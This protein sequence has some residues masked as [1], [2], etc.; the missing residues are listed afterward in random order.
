VWSPAGRSARGRTERCVNIFDFNHIASSKRR[1]ARY[2]EECC[3]RQY[4]LSCPACGN[5]KLY[6]IEKG[7]RRRC[8]RCGHS[9]SRFGRRWLNRVKLS[10]AEWL[11]AAKLFEIEMPALKAA[12]EISISYPT[13]LKTF[14]VIRCAIA[15]NIRR[16]PVGSILAP[17]E[18]VACRASDAKAHVIYDRPVPADRVYLKVDLG[19]TLIVFTDR[20]LASSTLSWRGSVLEV[21]DLGKQY[22][23]CR[24]YC[25]ERG[26]W[27]YAKERLMRYRGVT[28]DKMPLYL[29]EIELRRTHRMG[30]LLE[31]ILDTLCGVA[32]GEQRNEMESTLESGRKVSGQTD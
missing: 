26:F 14:N 2:L 5:R 13:L 24:V 25:N 15:S 23:R 20:D 21:A 4:A 16:L 10:P 28:I 3:R 11:W 31:A 17:A 19:D 18:D 7:K 6:I 32:S 12:K 29:A 9:F 22:P 8:A 30:M 1:S 27:P